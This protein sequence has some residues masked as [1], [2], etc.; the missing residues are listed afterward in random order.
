MNGYEKMREACA[1]IAEYAKSAQCH[2]EDAHVLGYLRQ[3]ENWAQAA[4]AIP[5]RQ[6][7]VGT[8]EEQAE[9]F[10]RFCGQF[11]CPECTLTGKSGRMFLC[12]A[13]WAQMPYAAQEGGAQ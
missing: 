11:A 2:T 1:N 13:Q 4:L 7:D 9:R 8:A 10:K 5:R 3:M 12:Y 6:C